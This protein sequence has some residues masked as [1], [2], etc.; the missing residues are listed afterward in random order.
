M[1]T[2]ETSFNNTFLPFYVSSPAPLVQPVGAE[3]LNKSVSPI[4]ETG[5]C[6]YLAV[7]QDPEIEPELGEIIHVVHGAIAKDG[8]RYST[9]RNLV[10]ISRWQQDAAVSA[11]R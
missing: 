2:L 9:L 11:T 4:A 10:D 8:S 3:C 1:S 7:L 6:A 5:L